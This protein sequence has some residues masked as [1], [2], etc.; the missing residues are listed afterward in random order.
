MQRYREI[1][2]NDASF[3]PKYTS[4]A[5]MLHAN[6]ARLMNFAKVHTLP[7]IKILN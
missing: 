5:V 7:L 6:V 1:A 4:Y 2:A 3:Y